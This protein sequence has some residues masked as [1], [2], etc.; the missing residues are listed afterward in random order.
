MPL[1]FVSFLIVFCSYVVV[2][3]AGPSGRDHRPESLPGSALVVRIIRPRLDP[4]LG[5][6]LSPQLFGLD[7]HLGFRSLRRHHLLR[8]YL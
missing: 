4:L 8:R 5:G 7:A 3:S 2:L 1:R 6:T